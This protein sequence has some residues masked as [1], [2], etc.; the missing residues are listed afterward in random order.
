M[1]TK[2][3][4]T[5]NFGKPLNINDYSYLLP[6]E[7]IAKYPLEKRDHSKLLIYKRQKNNILQDRFHNITEYLP[8]QSLLIFNNTKVIHAR[9]LF[10]KE[11]GAVIEIFCLHP[12]NPSDYQHAFQSV[13]QCSWICMVG[14]RKRWKKESITQ[15]LNIKGKEIVLTAS[16][17]EVN[18]DS[19]IVEFFWSDLKV[20]FGEI[21][22]CFGKIPIPPY[23]K[24]DA[25]ANDA[26]T[27]QTVYSKIQ[28]S[29]AAPTAG[30]HFTEEII[31]KLK[32]NN[33]DTREVT[34]HIGAGTFQPVK[35]EN[36]LAHNMHTEYFEVSGDLIRLFIEKK[37]PVIA[38]GTTSVRTIESIYW[39][40]VKLY[41]GRI[42][43]TDNIRV[44]Q[45]EPYNL[46]DNI[47]V[48]NSLKA[49]LK[50][51]NLHNTNKLHA[52]T[53]LMIIP[54]YKFRMAD[55][56]ITNFHQ[57]KST[58]LLLIAAFAGGQWKKIYEYALNNE[59]RFLSYGDSSL[60]LP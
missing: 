39:V 7:R 19:V 36:A 10:E 34:L 21:L 54:G 35:Q 15:T 18:E 3:Y 51:M 27:Y 47:T 31:Q 50:F 56:I 55:G 4:T 33:L 48:E 53:C 17:K 11:T 43:Q 14:N 16:K 42:Q 32:D 20:N 5:L 2:S 1:P 26:V 37:Q 45:W 23:L 28:G 9:M 38:V 59:F 60:L 44:E 12:V 58:L 40:G 24:R 6:E 29:V 52:S 30:L 13:A 22:E 8:P 46:P 25:E 41:S 49:I 57:P